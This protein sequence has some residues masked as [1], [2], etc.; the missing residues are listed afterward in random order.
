MSGPKMKFVVV[1][2]MAPRNPSVCAT[3]SRR[4]SEATCMIFPPQSAIVG[5]VLPPM[6]GGGWIRGI[7]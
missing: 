7:D 3:C 6:D 5:S 4:W 2:N 1:N